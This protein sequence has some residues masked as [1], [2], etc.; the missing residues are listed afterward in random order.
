MARG[1]GVDKAKLLDMVKKG[2]NAQEIMKA[3]KIKAKNSLKAALAEIM[4]ETGE[5]L[6]VTG[7]RGRQVGNR[8]VNKMGIIIPR[9]QLEPK[10]K[11]GDG[12][13]MTIEENTITLK[14]VR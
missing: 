11:I 5:V 1:K 3:L 14:K 6:V 2:K 12:F 13:E 7:L 9:A 8:K 10:F 4:M